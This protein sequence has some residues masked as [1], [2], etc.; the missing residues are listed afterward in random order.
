MGSRKAL[1]CTQ[2]RIINTVR[3]RLFYMD[4]SGQNLGR[5]C[6]CYLGSGTCKDD[7]LPNYD[8]VTCPLSCLG[9]CGLFSL[10]YFCLDNIEE[11]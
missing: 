6:L 4:D 9:Y 7:T 3:G 8:Y 10:I 1:R 11:S 2:T 5:N